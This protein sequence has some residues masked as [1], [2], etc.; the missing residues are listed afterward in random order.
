L[1]TTEKGGVS[2]GLKEMLDFNA[3][4]LSISTR[5]TTHSI[6][7]LEGRTTV[8]N[9]STCL[10]GARHALRSAYHPRPLSS[11]HHHASHPGISR[12]RQFS[13]SRR[14]RSAASAAKRPDDSDNPPSPNQHPSKP[15]F[16][17]QADLDS[18]LKDILNAK[19]KPIDMLQTYHNNYLMSQRQAQRPGGTTDHSLNSSLTGLMRD[20]PAQS[21]WSRQNT[22]SSSS[23][24]S[25][26][27]PVDSIKDLWAND[28]RDLDTSKN[29]SA[30][31]GNFVSMNLR[32]RGDSNVAVKLRTLS[33]LAV[34][35]KV[36]QTFNR[37]RFHERPGLKRKRLKSE[38]WRARFK[39]NFKAI[40]GR[41]G[42]FTKQ[43]W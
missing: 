42:D 41:V 40:C 18:V 4:T 12:L 8:M 13:Q 37:Q 17:R 20:R 38:R 27:N 10:T 35:N 34:N 21:L 22:S 5:L 3:I 30:K 43:G 15:T 31:F 7:G 14:R 39:R 25:S 32:G 29:L 19:K 9:S 6:H 23:S 24:L 36:P 11:T 16:D 28:A 26:S 33:A 1:S 2:S